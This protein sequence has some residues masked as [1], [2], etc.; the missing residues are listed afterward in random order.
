MLE[1]NEKLTLEESGELL[2]E[3]EEVS[4]AYY[5]AG[6]QLSDY[7]ENPQAAWRVR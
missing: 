1:A 6:Y 3:A 5:R 7:S 4:V 2:Y